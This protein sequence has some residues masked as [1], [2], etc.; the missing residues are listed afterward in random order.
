MASHVDQAANDILKALWPLPEGFY[1]REDGEQGVVL[2]GCSN[3]DLAFFI[4]QS[5]I[6][7]QCH[8]TRALYAFPRLIEAVREAREAAYNE[9]TNGAEDSV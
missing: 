1:V 3:P 2:I 7:D 6:A 5:E 9:A 8:V 4:T